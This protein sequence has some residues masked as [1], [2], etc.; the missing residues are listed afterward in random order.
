MGNA[1]VQSATIQN[2]A[3]AGGGFGSVPDG[4]GLEN[5]T[6]ITINAGS[7]VDFGTGPIKTG[8][9]GFGL[10][11]LQDQALGTALPLSYSDQYLSS[12]NNEF[13]DPA[14]REIREVDG[15][16]TLGGEYGRNDPNN[17][18]GTT[19]MD[20]GADVLPGERIMLSSWVRATAAGDI[21][22]S[23]WKT[24]R[25]T[26][27][28]NSSDLSNP[29]AFYTKTFVASSAS[30]SSVLDLYRPL[31]TERYDQQKINHPIYDGK[32]TRYD[33]FIE[34]SGEGL[35][36]GTAFSRGI[37]QGEI[38]IDKSFYGSSG[39]GIT[40]NGDLNTYSVGNTKYRWLRDQDFVN[41]T[42]VGGGQWVDNLEILRTDKYY[43]K[44]W[45]RVE[46][47]NSANET[48]MVLPTI[49]PYLT[50]S[51]SQITLKLYKGLNS[52]FAGKS[53]VVYDDND[54]IIAV[55]PIDSLVVTAEA[56]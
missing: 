31:S 28:G 3:Q 18:G 43:Q 6:L 52:D 46:L 40:G 17:R 12:W 39:A 25:V 55:A 13:S 30:G 42:I 47:V 29:D 15:I 23:Q 36:N 8:I 38:G 56:A 2:K 27:T 54:V 35:D 24:Y 34:P 4:G 49:Q 14:I 11:P 22:N 51:S 44:G 26:H 45:A 53:L 7:G 48:E 10:G 50:W 16:R 5:G 9:T 19:G 37:K 1:L 33:V 20:L 32:W 21:N 41:N